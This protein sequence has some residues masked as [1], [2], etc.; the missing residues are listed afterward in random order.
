MPSDGDGQDRPLR[1]ILV[2]YDDEEAADRALGRAAQL[3]EAFSARLV[4]L[5]IAPPIELSP[6]VEALEP[7]L[8]TTPIS[9]ARV[10]V[11]PAAVNPAADEPAHPI[12]HSHEHAER[13]RDLLAGRKVRA[14]LVEAAVEDAADAVVSL[15]ASYEAD[16][17]V[18]AA[19]RPTMWQRLFGQS[20]VAEVSRRTACDLFIVA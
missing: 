13:A 4:V 15:A 5:S 6:S 10:A 3:A 11:D 18:L 20:L 17:L 9:S 12:Q 19:H 7:S 8:G 1:T 16:L 2:A 14:E